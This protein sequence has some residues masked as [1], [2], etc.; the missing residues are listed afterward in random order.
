MKA[1]ILLFTFFFSFAAFSTFS[2]RGGGDDTPIEF[3]KFFHQAFYEIRDHQPDLYAKIS[4]V[5]WE[6]YV[7]SVPVYSTEE[8][9]RVKAGEGLQDSVADNG[10]G[11]IRVNSYRWKRVSHD[12]IRQ[13]IAL[14]EVL[15]TK[16][17]EGTGLYPVSSVYLAKCHMQS[18]PQI[19]ISGED[20]V[21]KSKLQSRRMTCSKTLDLVNRKTKARSH[22]QRLEVA[23]GADWKVLDHD[24]YL[25]YIFGVESKSQILIP[26]A[27]QGD[28]TEEW[29]PGFGMVA[30]S[31]GR[32][33][34]YTRADGHRLVDVSVPASDSF[35]EKAQDGRFA[36]WSF[37]GGKRG[38]LL[39]YITRTFMSN[40]AVR[41]YQETA[42]TNQR[43]PVWETT[44]STSD[45]LTENVEQDSW[46]Q[47]SG[48]PGIAFELEKIT[49]RVTLVNEADR[50]YKSCVPETCANL[51]QQLQA[52][53]KEFEEG[54][55]QLW[56]NRRKQIKKSVR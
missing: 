48:D 46:I 7:E 16:Q 40:G 23:A 24:Y 12:C 56:A 31:K 39:S 43:D 22:D 13:A 4:S 20:P 21:L 11:N 28:S 44:L 14:H 52:R 1:F 34:G 27:M 30:H 45:C 26:V 42:L 49:A 47:R 36:Q 51:K 32:F 29:K 6:N 38:E 10:D 37:V 17:I 2:V 53:V 15:S 18:D 25:Q 9:I 54:W 55:D 5:D 50:A 8:P 3:L 41:D 35:H 19:I 33:L